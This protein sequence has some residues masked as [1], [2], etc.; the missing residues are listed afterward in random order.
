[1][2]LNLIVFNF[3]DLKTIP[4]DFEKYLL[5]LNK[6]LLVIADSNFQFNTNLILRSEVI[7][8]KS[9]FYR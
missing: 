6:K 8:N 4:L 1:M 5:N 2:K 3:S 7:A 9:V